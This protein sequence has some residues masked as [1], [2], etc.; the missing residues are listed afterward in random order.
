MRLSGCTR[1]YEEQ[2]SSVGNREQLEEAIKYLRPGD[3]LVVTKLDRL[4]RSV[5]HLGEILEKIEEAGASLRILGMD[6]NTGNATGKL[7][8]TILG[9]VAEFERN[10]MKERQLEGIKR[11][12]EAGKYKGRAPTVRR[13]K[14]EIKR[15]VYEEGLGALKMALSCSSVNFSRSLFFLSCLL[16]FRSIS[17]A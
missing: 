13:Q 4:A 15:L 2:V 11:A 9:S 3:T 16:S 5:K 8:M 6:I 14:E 1:I 12:K 17:K 10:M 7:I